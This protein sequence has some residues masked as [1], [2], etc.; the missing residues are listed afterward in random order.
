MEQ[1]Q[2]EVNEIRV[3]LDPKSSEDKTLKIKAELEKINGVESV[4]YQTKDEAFND[5]KESF[6]DDKELL[7]G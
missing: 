3:A 5:M 7:E 6:G 1:T 2:N 4:K